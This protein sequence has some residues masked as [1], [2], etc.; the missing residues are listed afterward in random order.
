VERVVGI[1]LRA[2][3]PLGYLRHAGW[4]LGMISLDARDLSGSVPNGQ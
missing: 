3:L 1:A 2:P 4:K